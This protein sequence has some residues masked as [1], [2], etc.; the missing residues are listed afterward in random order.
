MKV[1]PL[2][3]AVPVVCLFLLAAACAPDAGPGD[4]IAGTEQRSSELVQ[5]CTAT[6]V[7][8]NPYKGRLCGGA[9]ID[10]CTP[11]LVY[12]CRG[13]ARGT[14][15]N[16]TLDT[17]CSVA[18]LTGAGD[19]PVTANIGTATPVANDAC[20]NGPAPLTFSTNSTT[21]GS[22]VTM[23]GTLT[24]PHS[25]YAIVNF[26]GTTA[27]VPPLC[28]PPLFLFPNTNSVSWIEPTNVVAAPKTVPLWALISFNDSNGAG[29]NLV[30]VTNPLT[31]NPGGTLP[32]PALASF[33]VSDANGTPIST[34]P[35]GSNAFAHGTLPASTPAPVGGTRVT[36][37]SNPANAFVTDGSFNIDAGC[38]SNTT[39]GTLTATSSLTS[40]LAAT[41]S[42]TSG[43][44]AALSQNVVVTPPALAVQS[45]T[46]TPSTVTGG[47]SLTGTVNLNR[48]V[49]S[50]DASS[51]VSVR[52]SEGNISGAK[53]ATFS[54][55]TGSPACTG[56]V[57]VPRGSRSASFTISTS[58]VGSQDFVTVAAGASWSNTSASAQLT[59][60]PS[61]NASASLSSL[62]ISP[63]SGFCGFS[64]T[65]TV[66]LTGP[67]PAGGAAVALSSSSTANAQVPASVTVAAGQ[68]QASFTATTGP[69]C[70]ASSVVIT[71]TYG[72]ASQQNALFFN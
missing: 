50:S 57:A 11:G 48:V 5:T 16:C 30:S 56:T 31:L 29:R 45:V 54:G 6:N 15:G 64:A 49:L 37:T 10:N 66:T 39:A 20:F 19:T 9:F 53:L 43:A 17:T 18:C 12:S 60:N 40:N 51:T 2:S 69:R 4:D 58:A 23:T 35:G 59:I 27:D 1:R 21:G 7:T 36:V 13:G 33:S 65:G 3:P 42:A 46:L 22:Y 8:G 61:G 55:C 41:V 26:K 62:V 38:F 67:A 24:Q 34:I 44:G 71:A 70:S 52:I 72:G 14:T 63:S 25:P 68:T 28:S 47:A 32:K